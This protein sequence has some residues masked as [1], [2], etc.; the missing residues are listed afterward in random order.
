MAFRIPRNPT[1]IESLQQGLNLATPGLI[2]G[3]QRRTA[4]DKQAQQQVAQQ[5]VAEQL[6]FNLPQ[7]INPQLGN[8]LIGQAQ[9]ASFDPASAASGFTLS[10]GQQR[11]DALGNPIA[12]V[13]GGGFTLGQGQQRFDESGRPIASV[14][15]AQP[16]PQGPSAFAEKQAQINALSNIPVEKRTPEQQA[17]LN[18]LLNVPEPKTKEETE[19]LKS[20]IAKNRADANKILRE[21]GGKPTAEQITTQGNTLRKE[22]DSLSKN[23]R[24]IRDSHGRLIASASDPSAAGD[25]AVIFNFMKILDPGSV[26]RES[27]F[28]TAEN[29]ASVPTAIR[30]MW[31]KALSGERLS[32]NRGDFVNQANNLLKSGQSTQ[33][34]L[35]SRYS[36][37]SKRFGV[38]PEDV[39]TEVGNVDSS[40]PSRSSLNPADLRNLTT[41]Q[42][43]NL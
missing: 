24:T 28:A 29:A 5:Q 31:N 30:N 17:Q 6:G 42:L 13:G 14:A 18:D 22:F 7:G 27:E 19:L 37:L 11:F 16:S 41:E 40:T 33:N 10:Q 21:S 9:K 8:L 1:L 32:I 4:L 43:Q 25:L 20:Q 34:K 15:A 2:Q 26:V 38:N 35:I 12:E 39:I 23:F 3:A 36:G